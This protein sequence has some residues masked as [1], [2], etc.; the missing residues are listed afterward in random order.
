[1]ITHNQSEAEMGTRSPGPLIA[2]GRTA[3]VYA[4]GE[5]Q[6]I[7]LFYAWMP[8]HWVQ[9]EV[10]IGQAVATMDLPTPKLVETVEVGGRQ[11]IIY[12]RADGPSMLRL[13]SARPWL[14]FHLA[15]QL[16]E[17]HSKI[18]KQN[19]GGL[20]PLRSSL[21]ATIQEV[22]NLP[23]GVKAG[24]LRL[25]DELPDADAL[26]HFDLHPDQVLVTA[27]GPVIID[28]MTAHQGH[29]LADVARTSVILMVGQPPYGG[30][31][32]RAFANLW[33]GL[34]SR[35]YVARYLELHPGATR[36]AIRSWMIPVAA[37]RLREEIPGEQRPILRFIQAHLLTE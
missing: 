7:K 12:E 6:I 17:L 13:S 21:N 3:E 4:W 34:F 31:A 15:R 8:L 25:L 20:T 32:M 10:E 24:V 37:G 26:C 28:W 27:K 19:G 9:H 33:R 18:H 2:I 16:A 11:G 22:E 1:M 23:L 35:T 30:W 5:D 14:L 36:D 29:P